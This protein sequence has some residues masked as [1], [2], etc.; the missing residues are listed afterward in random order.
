MLEAQ[1]NTPLVNNSLNAENLT[2]DIRVN[3]KI[4][5]E[6]KVPFIYF[7]ELSVKFG[8]FKKLGDI[9][10]LKN[11]CSI[12]SGFVDRWLAKSIKDKEIKILRDGEIEPRKSESVN[13]YSSDNQQESNEL[14]GNISNKITDI[15]LKDIATSSPKGISSCNF[16]ALKNHPDILLEY[17]ITFEKFMQDMLRLADKSA[18]LG[19]TDGKV[20]YVSVSTCTVDKEVLCEV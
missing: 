6:L 15:A 19:N 9:E 17:K 4:L 1:A 13:V 16:Y 8:L 2:N 20:H 12:Y 3:K 7:F 11:K 5:S 14:L 10:L 18:Q